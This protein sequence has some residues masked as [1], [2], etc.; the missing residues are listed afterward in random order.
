MLLSE[1][2]V[3]SSGALNCS[4][5]GLTKLSLPGCGTTRDR[6]CSL[7]WW[8]LKRWS[9]G[10]W[11]HKWEC[12]SNDQ[13]FA[14]LTFDVLC[15]CPRWNRYSKL[16]DQVEEFTA[17]CRLWVHM[18]DVSCVMLISDTRLWPTEWL[19][20]H[21]WNLPVW[22]PPPECRIG[23]WPGTTRFHRTFTTHCS[24]TCHG[25]RLLFACLAFHLIPNH[26]LLLMQAMNPPWSPCV[27]FWPWNIRLSPPL[28]APW[29]EFGVT[30]QEP[31]ERVNNSE[32][33]AVETH[34]LDLGW[35][36][37]VFR[38][39]GRGWHKSRSQD[40]QGG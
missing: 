8:Y 1:Y 27:P 10:R 7:I 15:Q 26:K 14:T 33:F 17:H 40:G 25:S 5:L 35:V 4:R 19:R 34:G 9:S 24:G 28:S 36:I 16:H 38:D 3:T 23:S 22:N 13:S 39:G 18:W 31:V 21:T 29:T 20:K 2:P 30:K 12:C 37:H 11:N 32:W 6:Y